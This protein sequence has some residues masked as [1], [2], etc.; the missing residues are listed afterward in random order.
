M[1]RSS[2]GFVYKL[3]SSLGVNVRVRIVV[4]TYRYSILNLSPANK[5][6]TRQ[7]LNA[8]FLLGLHFPLETM[9]LVACRASSHQSVPTTWWIQ[10]L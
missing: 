2:L 9:T 1:I 6:R 4:G 7:L 8:S 5:E 3:V 10:R